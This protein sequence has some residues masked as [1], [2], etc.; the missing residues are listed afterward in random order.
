MHFQKL[1]NAEDAQLEIQEIAK[2]MLRLVKEDGS[3]Q[4]SLAAYGF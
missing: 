4:H 1:R 3:F 2:E